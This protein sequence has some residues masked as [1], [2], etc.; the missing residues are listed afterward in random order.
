MESDLCRLSFGVRHD[1]VPAQVLIDSL[2][3]PEE[4]LLMESWQR[5]GKSG[6]YSHIYPPRPCPCARGARSSNRLLHGALR[7]YQ[8]RIR[9][10][11]P[12]T[13]TPHHRCMQEDKD[14]RINLN[15]STAL[16]PCIVVQSK[17]YPRSVFP[18]NRSDL[19]SMKFSLP[20]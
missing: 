20:K 3:N 15:G 13:P 1:G 17:M 8:A 7:S 12:S 19:S 6:L 14:S 10:E 5:R 4:S 9:G 2:R 16:A 18:R 11:A